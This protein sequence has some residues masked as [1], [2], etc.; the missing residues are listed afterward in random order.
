M[1]HIQQKSNPS[2]YC[3]R[4][5]P[6]VLHET[7]VKCFVLCA[8]LLL[9]TSKSNQHFTQFSSGKHT[10]RVT[11]MWR[12]WSRQTSVMGV[13]FLFPLKIKCILYGFLKP[14]PDVTNLPLIFIY[15]SLLAPCLSA[16]AQG[17]PP[18]VKVFQK[19]YLLHWSYS[20]GNSGLSSLIINNLTVKKVWSRQAVLVKCYEST[21][22]AKRRWTN[23]VNFTFLWQNPSNIEITAFFFK[24][25]TKTHCCVA[26]IHQKSPTETLQRHWIM[27][28]K[29]VLWNIMKAADL[30]PLTL[31]VHSHKPCLI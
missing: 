24:A 18:R 2:K 12:Q 31:R 13:F 23:K 26:E 29:V 11:G 20:W 3:E 9:N 14:W 1:C 21:F 6:D 7:A 5:L 30:T 22:V 16:Q 15:F 10:H 8:T 28:R 25:T 4:Q 17:H 19:F 27:T